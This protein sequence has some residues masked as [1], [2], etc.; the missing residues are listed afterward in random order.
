MVTL[1]NIYDILQ[2]ELGLC[3]IENNKREALLIINKNTALTQNDLY[4][5]GSEPITDEQYNNIIADLKRR[6]KG[7]PLQ[8]IL[9]SWEFFGLD[10]IVGEGVL[11]PRQDTET[12]VET[13]IET[14]RDNKNLVIADLCSGTGCVAISLDKN[15]MDS[16]VYAFELS[17]KAFEYLDMNIKHNDSNVISVKADVL[18][19]NLSDYEDKFDIIVSNP[20]YLNDEDMLKIQREVAFEPKMALY[21]KNNGLMFYQNIAKRW[22]ICIKK[23]GI[24]AFEIGI[25]QYD[26][27]K[28]ILESNGYENVCTQCDLCG[29]IRVVFAIKK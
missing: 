14:V 23:G 2:Y 7:E 13:V 16:N 6:K 22:K 17:D 25:G 29:I 28:G 12:L 20:P 24:L 19:C 5:R 4:I 18:S 11:I 1:K 21:A 15:I 26:D 3:G 10:F 8:Y 27:I 9:G